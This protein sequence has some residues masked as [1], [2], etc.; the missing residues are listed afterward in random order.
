MI[1]L[2]SK[3]S[4]SVWGGLA[5]LCRRVVDFA[6]NCHRLDVGAAQFA[7]VVGDDFAADFA[8]EQSQALGGLT[9]FVGDQVAG[10][11][12]A[13]H[14][15]GGGMAV[16]AT[17]VGICHQQAIPVVMVGGGGVDGFAEAFANLVFGFAVVQ[18]D[19]FAVGDLDKLVRDASGGRRFAAL[20]AQLA[21]SLG[22]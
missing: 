7:V 19:Q 1:P 21:G 10:I 4:P 18:A 14:L 8:L 22:P 13:Q 2:K 9:A 16:V 6:D 15:L 20:R 3:P 12:Q 17:V 5:D 11:P